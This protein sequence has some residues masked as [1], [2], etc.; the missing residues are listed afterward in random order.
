MHQPHVSR[1]IPGVLAL[2]TALT[3][4]LLTVSTA[5]AATPTVSSVNPASGPTAG[6]TTV[7][8]TG[9]GLT[10]T[11]GVKFGLMPAT[12]FT[13]VNDTTVTAVAPSHAAGTVDVTVTNADGT[14]T[15]VAGD[16]FTFLSAPTVSNV[17]PVSGPTTGGTV[18]TVTGTGFVT[19]PGN[20]SVSFGGTPS[21]SVA[22]ASATQLTALA[23]ARAAGAI[24]IRVTTA[25][26]TSAAT[27]LTDTFTYVAAAPNITSL[28]PAAGPPAGGT[29][30]TITGSGFTGATGAT[31]GGVAAAGFIV[32]SDTQVRAISP[33]HLAG[34][35]DVVVNGPGG[36]S[37]TSTATKF[38]YTAAGI[39]VVTSVSPA[40]TTVAGGT[41]VSITGSGFTGATGVTFGGTAG[42]AV[43]V[44]S[45]TSLLVTAPAHAA[46]VVDVLVTA[47]GGVSV[48][49]A[50]SKFTYGTLPVITSIS[51]ATGGSGTVVTITG[52]GFTGATSVM[53]GT[54]SA[55]PT[56][57]SDTTVVVTAPTGVTGAVDIQV[58]TPS[59]T[60]AIVAAGRF[61]FPG[62]TVTYTLA[63]RWS[64]IVWQGTDGISV[65]AALRGLETP[66]N[67]A[68][69]DVSG[70]VTA[71]YRW[72][73]TAQKWDGFFPGSE[74][75][76]GANDFTT[77][78]KGVAYWTAIN[79]S[80]AVTWTI[81][82]G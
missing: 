1:R 45:D 46:G 80:S 50:G 38:N 3:L 25:G 48:A 24:D 12:S 13:F 72:N 2:L 17:S 9:T 5:F 75:I 43:T 77:L 44:L 69:N 23:P 33:A 82:Q 31:F 28:S 74:S 18:V 81:Q 30:V 20:T 59:G 8:I 66:D 7:T 62:S 73:A 55:T 76:P 21:T 47:P 34:I 52:T 22:V 14:S 68:T 63:V 16:Q 11:T 56:S 61:T 58:V 19:G 37:A 71:M 79:G 67:P 27:P 26:G 36:A 53:F 6:G 10:G 51:P 65:T 60:S 70:R 4:A 57:V 64:L 54:V 39:P 42:T 49:A 29:T 32:D 41:V 35:V 15:V 40:S 78:T